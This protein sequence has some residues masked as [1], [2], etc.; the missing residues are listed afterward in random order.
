[1]AKHGGFQGKN[2]T[3]WP[4]IGIL[5]VKMVKNSHFQGKI[6]LTPVKMRHVETTMRGKIASKGSKRG[7]FRV[8]GAK[9]GQK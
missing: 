5:E 7:I 6:G 2:G 1:M 8:K 9:S 3:K 4:K